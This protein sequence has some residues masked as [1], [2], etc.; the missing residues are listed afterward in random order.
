VSDVGDGLGSPSYGRTMQVRRFEKRRRGRRTPKRF[1]ARKLAVPLRRSPV[2]V[3]AASHRCD[4]L[5]SPSYGRTMQVR[6]FKK[7]RRGRRTPKRF[8][9]R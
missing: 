2:I 4:G 8:F 5:G 1:F 3:E 9:A 7:R 6:R